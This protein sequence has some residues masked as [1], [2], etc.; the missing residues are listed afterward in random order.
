MGL[1]SRPRRRTWGSTPARGRF[2]TVMANP[3]ARIGLGLLSSYAARRA[4]SRRRYGW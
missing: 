3:W 4:Y 1:F 2:G